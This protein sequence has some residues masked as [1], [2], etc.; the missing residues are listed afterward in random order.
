MVRGR[1][2]GKQLLK[3][4]VVD[5]GGVVMVDLFPRSIRRPQA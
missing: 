4:L 3:G 5:G 2:G 1:R